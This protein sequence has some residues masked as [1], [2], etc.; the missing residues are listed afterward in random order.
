[1]DVN[2]DGKVDF[3]EMTQINFRQQRSVGPEKLQSQAIW[4]GWTSFLASYR[5]KLYG[6]ATWPIH[7]IN[8]KLPNQW[9][10]E[11]RPGKP[12]RPG[13]AVRRAGKT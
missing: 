6:Q 1:M 2:K 9:E 12:S 11:R 10:P 3:P 13:A 4:P 8:S 7:R 5:V